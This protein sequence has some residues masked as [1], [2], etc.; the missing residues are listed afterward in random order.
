M[1]Y[2]CP[3]L[4]EEIP[5]AYGCGFCKICRIEFK[6]VKDATIY[7]GKVLSEVPRMRDARC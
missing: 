5:S 2:I 6:G 1:P 7:Y 4:E 3:K